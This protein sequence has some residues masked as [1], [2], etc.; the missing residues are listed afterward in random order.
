MR[1][2]YT[3]YD[4]VKDA[5][6]CYS[7]VRDPDTA[8][9]IMMRAVRVLQQTRTEDEIIALATDPRAWEDAVCLHVRAGHT[10]HG[11]IHLSREIVPLLILAIEEERLG[12]QAPASIPVF[13]K[14]RHFADKLAARMTAA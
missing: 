4:A 2:E 14:G 13:S 11:D 1:D 5:V 12:V 3:G 9:N 6:R 8:A 7:R 10:G